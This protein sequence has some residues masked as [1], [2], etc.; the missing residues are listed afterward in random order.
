MPVFAA[1]ASR[2]LLLA[3]AALAAV[4]LA[5]AQP[6]R[7]DDPA[8]LVA[9]MDRYARALRSSD[10]EALVGLY[11]ANGV[12]MRENMSAVTGVDALRAAY[13]NIFATLK[14][15]LSFEIQETEMAG[16]MAWLRSISKGRIKTLA[17]GA[18]ADESFNQLIVF[19]RDGADWK[20]RCYLYAS[21]KPGS[22]T[23]Q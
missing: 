1:L 4:G 13:R 6:G 10:V 11:A 18:E 23:P 19:R 16:E 14:A 12:L 21:S 15:D 2:R 20:I 7:A 9:I 22:G 8:P 3:S 17:T 5:D